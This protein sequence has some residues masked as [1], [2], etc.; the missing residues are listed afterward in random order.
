[1][2]SHNCNTA[3]LLL[4]ISA[5]LIFLFVGLVPFMNEPLFGIS[6]F[7]QWS[8]AHFL[9]YFTLGALCPDHLA[10]F[11]LIG[12]AWE[13][14]ERFFATM[15]D[16]TKLWTNTGFKGQVFDILMN[17]FGYKSSELFYSIFNI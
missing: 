11:M 3:A 2:S 14:L 10:E 5:V 4:F 1:M 7:T 16:K 17:F 8:G 12:I 9:L 13:L 15:T 6:F